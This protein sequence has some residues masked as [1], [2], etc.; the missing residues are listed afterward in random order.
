LECQREEEL[1][2][3][4]ASLHSDPK[5]LTSWPMEK[6]CSVIYTHEVF[7]KFQEK[8]VVARDHCIIQR[9]SESKDMKIVTISSLSGKE[10]VVQM[11]KS[12]MFGTCSCKLYE[13]YGIPCHHVIQV[14]R[15]ESKS[16]F[17]QFI[18]WRD[19][20][21]DVKGECTT[22]FLVYGCFVFNVG[23]CW[24]ETFDFAEK[25]F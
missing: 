1:K 7:S 9:I 23:K 24:F 10:R 2:A 14:L 12:N 22:V 11:N 5:L 17:H 18:L 25:C 19:G 21:K 20:R 6:Q 15:G 16:R 8:L 3:D 13:S 4:N